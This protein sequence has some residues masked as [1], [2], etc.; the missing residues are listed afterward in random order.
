M[1]TTSFIG[2]T[3]I[4]D[5]CSFRGEGFRYPKATIMPPRPEFPPRGVPAVG[6]GGSDSG[7][8]F[9]ASLSSVRGG[10]RFQIVEQSSPMLPA[11][12]RNSIEVTEFL[13]N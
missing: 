7:A 5:D 2:I 12:W 4:I 9:Q 6:A 8:G 10:E 3:G 1:R 11:R 13:Q